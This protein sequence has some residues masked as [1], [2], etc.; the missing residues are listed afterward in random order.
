MSKFHNMRARNEAHF[1]VCETGCFAFKSAAC[2]FREG[3][4]EG[5]GRRKTER[6]WLIRDTYIYIYQEKGKNRAHPNLPSADAATGTKRKGLGG[7]FLI[8]R[9]IA[10]RQARGRHLD[11]ENWRGCDGRRGC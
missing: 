5:E 11:P 1:E 3:G 2:F 4:K 10:R 9:E 6:R 7:L 8:G